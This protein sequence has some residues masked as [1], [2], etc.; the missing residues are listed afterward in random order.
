MIYSSCFN[1]KAGFMANY[2][3]TKKAMDSLIFQAIYVDSR[4][5]TLWARADPLYKTVSTGH[6]FIFTDNLKMSN[7]LVYSYG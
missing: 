3:L 2:N 4:D 1:Y 6:T 5:L 7:E